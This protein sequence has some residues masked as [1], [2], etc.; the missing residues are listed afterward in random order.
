MVT[1]KLDEAKKVF[2]IEIDALRNIRDALGAT[3]LEILN[4]II[5]CT[6]K[7]IWT[8]MGKSGHIAK[9]N[10]STMSSLGTPSFFLHPAEALH[11][12][13]GMI[14]SNDIIIAISHSGESD[15]ILRMLPSIKLMGVRVIGM[16][17]NGKSSLAQN[18]DI[19][20]IFPKCK[21]ACH[22]GMAPTS[23]TTGTLVYGDALAVVASEA[24]GFKK[25]DFGVFH[26]AGALGRKIL[27]KVSDIMHQNDEKPV[28]DKNVSL[29]DAIVEMSK[30]GQGL[31]TAIDNGQIAGVITDGD[32]RRALEKEIDV[33]KVLAKDIMTSNPIYIGES[34]LAID[35]LALMKE[36]NIAAM[37]VVN[38]KN[39]YTGVITVQAC[40]RVF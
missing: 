22:I 19:V 25:E 36:K 6:G 24:Y 12:D 1:G 30:K 2:D 17:Y 40:L 21:E 13:L 3:F 11:G 37:P 35:A 28:V 23:S 5:G 26:P 8:G 14:S 33:Y 38:M 4:E 15:E 16:T 29:K 18:C 10:A 9:K 32:L 34:S 7:I 31:V 20:Q 27:M 39:E